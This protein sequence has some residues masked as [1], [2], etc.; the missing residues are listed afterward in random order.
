MILAF[1]FLFANVISIISPSF[2]FVEGFA[3]L[4]LIETLPFSQASLATVLLFIILETFK[5]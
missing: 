4:S 3:T 5:Y 2:I 1:N